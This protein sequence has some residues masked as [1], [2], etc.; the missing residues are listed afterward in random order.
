MAALENP[1]HERFAQCVAKGMTQIEAYKEA[2]YKPNE[3][4]ASRLASNG[5]VQ[6]RIAQILTSAATRVEINLA[7][8]TEHLLRVATKA[9]ALADSGGL[10]VARG[11]YSDIAKMHGITVDKHE[12]SGP[13]GSAIPHALTVK[14]V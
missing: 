11:S 10:S 4:H 8:I 2:G 5:K 13:G 1:K 6:A 7:T 9:E 14:F 3:A 12:H